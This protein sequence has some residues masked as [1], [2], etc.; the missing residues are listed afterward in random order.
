MKNKIVFPLLTLFLIVVVVEV[1]GQIRSWS[2][3]VSKYDSSDV[4]KKTELFPNLKRVLCIGES[5]TEGSYP[6]A[7]QET[8]DEKFGR[9]FQV[10]DSGYGGVS[11]KFFVK[12]ISK[13]YTQTKPHYAVLMMGI[14]DKFRISNLVKEET[15]FYN[16]LFL[17]RLITYFTDLLKSTSTEEKLLRLINSNQ[18]GDARKLF[19]RS[20]REINDLE[21]YQMGIDVIYDSIESNVDLFNLY[22]YG[23]D[24]FN[25]DSFRFNRLW[26]LADLKD[27]QLENRDNLISAEI[28][29]FTNKKGW[30]HRIGDFY[31][32]AIKDIKTA[33]DYFIKALDKNENFEKDSKESALIA[34]KELPAYLDKLLQGFENE[35]YSMLSPYLSR[36][37][38]SIQNKKISERIQNQAF[39][40]DEKQFD[41]YTLDNILKVAS[42]LSSKGVKVLISQYPLRSVKIFDNRFDEFLKIEN[43]VNFQKLLG[44]YRY[45]EVFTD[46]FGGDFGHMTILGQRELAKNLSLHIKP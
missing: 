26:T 2:L 14:N 30:N 3:R 1:V 8:L 10:I 9:R 31:F 37:H 36:V 24:K 35:D 39:I 11:T 34:L 12:N 33:N 28:N 38:S 5:T 40:F 13:I 18:I 45:D 15:K 44:K 27:S 16:K 22:S 20:Y 32:R 4:L 46:N 41:Q 19:L 23:V 17:Y 43:R 7:L 25:N 21:A 6:Y 42:Y 29:Y